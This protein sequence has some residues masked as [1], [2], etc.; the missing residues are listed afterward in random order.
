MNKQGDKALLKIAWKTKFNQD[1]CIEPYVI[2]AVRNN[3]IVRALKNK[4]MDI[5]KKSN[6]LQGT[7]CGPSWGRVTYTAV[8]SAKYSQLI[9]K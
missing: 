2:I 9:A 8:G 6:S 5:F 7:S 3:G 1:A 4:D